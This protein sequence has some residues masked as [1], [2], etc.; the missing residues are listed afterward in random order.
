MTA[1][2][3]GPGVTHR[4][5][6]LRSSAAHPD[7]VAWLHATT[8][9]GAD[10]DG[11]Q[12]NPFQVA[13]ELGV[14]RLDAV[15]SFL[16][17]TR[18][19]VT[20]LTW[21]IHCPSCTGQPEY[22]R[23]LMQLDARAHC[24]LCDLRWDLDIE[25]Q[26]AVSFTLNPDVRRIDT[27]RFLERSWPACRER[28]QARLARDRRFPP[29]VAVIPR[30]QTTLGPPGLLDPGAHDVE[31]PGHPEGRATLVVA[32]EPTDELQDLRLHCGAAGEVTLEQA[33]LRPGPARM[34]VT[35][36]YPRPDWGAHVRPRRPPRHW[37]SAAYVT[38]LQDFRDLF[39]GEYLAPDRSFA[40]RSATL[41]FT[42]IKGSTALYERLGDARAYALV[43]RHFEVMTE[44]IRRREGGIVKTIGDA[45]MA[46]FP[47]NRD[48]ALAALE[49]Q[50]AFAHIAAPLDAITVKIGVHRGPT[51]AVTSN[52]ALDYFGRT[53][54][55]AARLQ[56]A[57]SPGEVLLSEAV[58]D[59]PEVRAALADRGLAPAWQDLALKGIAGG[60][61]AAAVR[62]A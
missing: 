37:V 17:A 9:T 20:D 5:D 10:V 41:M 6:A 25:D 30:G 53:V 62:P 16:F 61:R 14:P 7:V 27:D 50:Q 11:Y 13:E 57:S 28:L 54:N 23:H 15:R 1:P 44:V 47:V 56:G 8:T 31:V 43:Q 49:I 32:G 40:V 45:V 35:S 21:D 24:P 2:V 34:V 59:D 38:S 12:M 52:R 26:L 42:D 22:H 39:A 46:A 55:L 4:F 51:I 60:V 19:G 29:L 48:G 33:R 3:L 18:L 36:D 58:L